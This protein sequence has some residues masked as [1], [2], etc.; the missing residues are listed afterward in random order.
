MFDKIWDYVVNNWVFLV[1]TLFGFVA[2]YCTIFSFQRKDNKGMFVMQLIAAAFF[3]VQYLLLGYWS[4][5]VFNAITCV[6]GLV[7]YRGGKTADSAIMRGVLLAAYTVTLLVCII[8]LDEWQ[9][10]FAYIA[11]AVSTLSMWT[12][13]GKLIR[14]VQLAVVSPAWIAYGALTESI[15]G[16]VCELVSMTSV[17]ISFIR[18]GS[19]G[20]EVRKKHD[21]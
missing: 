17:V 6:R 4:G 21:K 5:L 14:I 2:A 20:F 15:A 19:S 10:I 12:G 11:L 1:A 9:A 3:G 7:L 13:N 8:W 18:H 16:I